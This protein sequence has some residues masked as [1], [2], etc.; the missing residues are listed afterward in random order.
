[1][2]WPGAI[3][4]SQALFSPREQRQARKNAYLT[5]ILRAKPDF[6]M[7]QELHSTVGSIAGWTPPRGYR[8]LHLHASIS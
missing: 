8:L 3:W 2:S 6:I 5:S 4:N 7:L 1:M